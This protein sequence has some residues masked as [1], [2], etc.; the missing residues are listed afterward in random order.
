VEFPSQRWKM[1][2]KITKEK[3]TM[4]QMFDREE[5]I[6]LTREGM[7]NTL[8]FYNSFNENL[9]K[10]SDWQ[11]EAINENNTRAVE[12]MNKSYDEYQKNSRVIMSRIETVCREALDKTAPKAKESGK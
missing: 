10:I 5:M 9:L 2:K 6:R 1:E 11:R 12:M 3:P 4:T 7:E 8:R